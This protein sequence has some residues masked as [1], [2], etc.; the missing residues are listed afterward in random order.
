MLSDYSAGEVLKFKNLVPE[1]SYGELIKHIDDH[2]ISKVTITSNMETVVSENEKTYGMLTTDYSITKINPYL[3]NSIVERTNKEHIQTTILQPV[4]ISY[5][6]S[7]LRTAFQ[8]ADSYLFPIIFLSFIFS[9]FRNAAG[10]SGGMP[11]MPG[12]PGMSRGKNIDAD[13]LLVTKSNIT[14]NS[15]A[16]SQEI[17]EECTE[18][19]SYLKNDTLYKAAGA[20]IPRGIL[21]EGPP[22]TG[23]TLLAKA[24]ASEADANFIAVAAS[25]FVELFVGMG[26]A[27]IRELFKKARENKP[28][29]LFIDEID[30]VG[31]QRGAGINLSNDEREQTLNQL[32]AEM[33]GFADNEG[34]LVIAAT[35]RKDV[36]DSALLRPGRFDRLIT[37]PL[38]DRNSRKEIFNVHAK[39]KALSPEIEFDTIA[40]LTGGF[41]GA[42]IKNILNEAAIFAARKGNKV[43][44]QID[45]LNALDKSLVGIVKKNDTRSY[46]SRYRVA[47]HET[48]HAFLA[49]HF[50]ENFELKKVT[51]Q[52][53]YNGAGG[54]TIFNEYQNISESG[55]YTKEI[56]TQRLIIGMGGKAAESVFYGDENVSLGATQDLKQTNSLA[57]QM[58]GNY[59]MGE[60]LQTFYNENVGSDRN[61]FLGRTLGNSYKYSENIK[62]ISDKEVLELVRTAYARAKL[63]LSENKQIV[64]EIVDELMEKN[65]LYA[66]DVYDLFTNS[67]V[68]A[69]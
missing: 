68:G 46:E 31:R 65:T 9:L 67:T 52:S 69:E 60:E 62:A 59:G 54:Y 25:E 19:V 40:E 18:V 8:F 16:G 5:P 50:K 12:M 29:I 6:E 4:P 3:V 35:N 41:S 24:I 49:A 61:P 13:K 26:A 39:N 1:T 57:Q 37:V 53:T 48:G 30:A 17:F 15:F 43:I 47:I 58:I 2:D 33:D 28:C 21:L 10:I 38:P 42:Q 56:L 51:I 44:E 27:R 63:L 11:G 23:K 14:I 22:G 20:E 66:K 45:L 64:D 34:I 32:L 36:L 55:L 7:L